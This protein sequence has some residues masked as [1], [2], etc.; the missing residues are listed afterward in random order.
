MDGS[1]KLK[2]RACVRGSSHK[3]SGA[4]VSVGE[5]IFIPIGKF[6]LTKS[7][8]LGDDNSVVRAAFTLEDEASALTGKLFS[9]I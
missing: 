7:L 3:T 4:M 5:R 2:R 9:Q 8:N 1:V 6:V